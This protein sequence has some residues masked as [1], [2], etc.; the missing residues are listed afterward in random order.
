MSSPIFTNHNRATRNSG[1]HQSEAWILAPKVVPNETLWSF[2]YLGLIKEIEGAQPSTGK[3]IAH[4]PYADWYQH[5]EC[6]FA[7]ERIKKTC[8]FFPDSS[9]Q[10]NSNWEFQSRIRKCVPYLIQDN[11]A[12][13]FSL[14]FH[15]TNYVTCKFLK[16]LLCMVSHELQRA[17][18]IFKGLSRFELDLSS[19]KTKLKLQCLRIKKVDLKCYGLS[20]MATAIHEDVPGNV[21]ALQ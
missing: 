15:R 1:S 4:D 2:G 18:I 17:H 21:H 19:L 10:D 13:H 20:V 3:T 14:L 12:A 16:T 7:N 5:R 11:F 8:P 9:W 6:T